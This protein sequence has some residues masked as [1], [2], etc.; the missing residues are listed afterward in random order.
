[1]LWGATMN[2]LGELQPVAVSNI[3]PLPSD[4][5]IEARIDGEITTLWSA[6][7]AGRATTKRTKLELEATRHDLGDRLWQM[8]SLLVCAGRLGGW[9]AYLRAHQL[10]RATAD[11]YISQLQASMVPEANRLSE[12]ICEPTKEDV[13]HLVQKL[14]PKLRRILTTQELV[15]EFIFQVVQQLS[16]G[17]L[18]GC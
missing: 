18:Q 5:E 6:H 13:H 4:A 8:K 15:S 7:Q 12:A 14:L 9:S 11:R 3:V 1:M 17:S 10:P 16:A 2:E